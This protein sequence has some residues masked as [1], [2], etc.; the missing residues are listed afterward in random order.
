[1]TL[2]PDEEK[3]LAELSGRH[4]RLTADE[5]GE[6]HRLRMA[7]IPKAIKPYY[8]LADPS[9]IPL[10]AGPLLSP[11]RQ[12]KAAE[13]VDG[14]VSLRLAPSPRLLTR[15]THNRQFDLNDLVEGMR[16]LQLPPI[17]TVPN[18][19]EAL[20]ETGNV[21]WP[22]PVKGFIVGNAAAVPRVT[23]HLANFTPIIGAIITD[24]VNAWTGRVTVNAGPWVV[25][26][27]ARP[28]LDEV[29]AAA[30][31]RGGNAITHTCSLERRDMRPF[32]Y[33]RCQE[34]LTCLTWCLWFC[35]ASAP[36]VLVPVGFDS[37]DRAMWS[38]WAAPHTD[39]LPDGHGRW[40]DTVYG[41]KQLAELFPLFWQRYNDPVWQQS[42]KLAVRYYAGAAMPGTLQRSVILAQVGLEALAYAHLVGATQ[43]MQQK[44]FKKPPISKH[45]RRFLNDFDIPITIPRTFYGLRSVR[46]SKPW[47]GPT[48]VAWLR[49]DIVHGDNHTV[50]AGRWRTWYQGWQLAVRYLELAVLAVVEYSGCYRNRLSDQV[51]A[52]AVEPVPWA[53]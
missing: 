35:R 27:D 33:A 52:G 29:L 22:G 8:S 13:Q 19:P 2:S 41:A 7:A 37:N 3:R 53:V 5:A 6:W 46:A 31:E 26:I 44:D 45:I 39:P 30:G 47:D 43:K 36:S 11:P 4:D 25:T 34:L 9:A 21:S 38:L 40:F 18:A 49:N 24:G 15:A 32:A 48:A 20:S 23:F 16:P 1:V 10:Y 50:H 42:L 12:G 28:D 51:H 17:L 14:T